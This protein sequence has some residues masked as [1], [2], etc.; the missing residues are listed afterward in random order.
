MLFMLCL[1]AAVLI[2][3]VV[4]P[5]FRGSVTLNLLAAGATV[6][7][8]KQGT[9]TET[10]DSI[11]TN[12]TASTL[13]ASNLLPETREQSV[14]RCRVNIQAQFSAGGAG[15]PPNFAGQT[16]GD[17]PCVIIF[18]D[19]ITGN[20]KIEEIANSIDVNGDINYTLAMISNGAYTRTRGT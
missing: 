12:S 17:V 10:I 8:I 13:D 15:D 18:G 7:G 5:G 20:F 14:K 16:A 2:L 3:G 9:V 4:K 6:L 1:I 11:I 19:T